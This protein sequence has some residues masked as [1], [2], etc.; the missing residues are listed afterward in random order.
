MMG[1][2]MIR[3]EWM[4][5][6]NHLWFNSD[7]ERVLAQGNPDF[8]SRWDHRFNIHIGFYF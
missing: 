4:A 6:Q 7:F 5:G 1:A 3:P 8:P 2:V